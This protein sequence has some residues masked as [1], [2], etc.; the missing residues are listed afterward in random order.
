M[1]C[2]PRDAE[3]ATAKVFNGM[4]GRRGSS[5]AKSGSPP[6]IECVLPERI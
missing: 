5:E 2:K 1:Y 6:F 4:L 3:K